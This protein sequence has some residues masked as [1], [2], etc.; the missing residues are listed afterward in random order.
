[1]PTPLA[2][3]SF[4]GITCASASLC[5]AVGNDTFVS[6]N[7]TGGAAAWSQGDPT[8]DDAVIDPAASCV[9]TLC[10]LG[11]FTG[12]LVSG[13]THTLTVGRAGTGSGSVSGS[14]ITCPGSCSSSYPAGTSVTLSPSPA[15]GST[16]T[17]W[18]GACSG[19]GGCTV[20]LGQDQAV[21]ATFTAQQ[22]QVIPPPKPT[23]KPS[24]HFTV[25]SKKVSTRGV[26]SLRLRVPGRGKLSARGTYVVK[27]AKHRTRTVVF[28]TA[29]ASPRGAGT[30]T[31]TVK[32]S[33]TTLKL[34]RTGAS[35]KLSVTIS[36][37]PTGGTRRTGTAK[38]TIKLKRAA[39]KRR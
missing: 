9:P 34:L 10:V 37:T 19:T 4:N 17:G 21:T 23:P 12:A 18:S 11:T 3:G 20:T 8:N 5:M 30:P 24:N 35:V 15:A 38:L 22:T 1:M 2:A 25:L 32:P 36:Y 39:P 16:F 26:V 7:P 13:S 27:L 29:S 31:L 6:T 14:A 33:S 28:G